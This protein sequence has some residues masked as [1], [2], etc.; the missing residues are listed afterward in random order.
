M[1]FGLLPVLEVEGGQVV[2]AESNTICRFIAKKVGLYGSGD[3][4]VEQAQI[5]MVVDNLA[6]LENGE[7]SQISNYTMR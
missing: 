7:E 6:D 5:D 3:D 4:P 1:P 2:I